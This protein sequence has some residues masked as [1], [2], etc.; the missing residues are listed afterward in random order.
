MKRVLT[1]AALATLTATMLAMPA[2][3]GTMEGDCSAS[4][5]SADSFRADGSALDSKTVETA[6]EANPF[7]VDPEGSVAWDAR[8]DVPIENHTWSIGLT[9][10]NL[11][12]QFFSGGDPNTA[13]TQTS[14]G[15][16][17]I[18]DRLDKIQNTLME[19]VIGELNGKL[20]VW[21]SIEGDDGKFCEGTAW[22]EIDGGFGTIG[23]AAA[24]LA[25]AGGAMM[26]WAGAKKPA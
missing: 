12:P 15:T 14:V 10:G 22:V 17:S 4:A 23:L 20:E 2:W 9:I 5:I 19:W 13:Q 16:V 1:I 25:A 11:T 7:K 6:T 3:G 18:K 24:A 26:V 21:G 8:S